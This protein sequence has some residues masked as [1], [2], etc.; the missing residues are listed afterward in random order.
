MSASGAIASE[1]SS[2]NRLK[3]PAGQANGL[4]VMTGSAEEILGLSQSPNEPPCVI[5]F[6]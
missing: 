4:Q 6:R 1:A 3:S 5:S 2:Y